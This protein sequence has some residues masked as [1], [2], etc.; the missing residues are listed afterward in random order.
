MILLLFLTALF[1]VTYILLQDYRRITQLRYMTR[2]EK[3]CKRFG[4]IRHQLVLAYARG[5]L[6]QEDEKAFRYLHVACTR[7]LHAPNFF[8]EVSTAICVAIAGDA[9]PKLVESLAP[10]DLSPATR[11]LMK[12]FV[13]SLDA[14]IEEFAHPLLAV[15]AAM[16]GRS[17]LDFVVQ[18]RDA[19]R[20]VERRRHEL[21]RLRRA[22]AEALAV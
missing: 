5:E 17:V 11:P 9:V 16:N 6:R 12:E 15:F 10:G 1:L 2:A 14:L 22:G 3:A 21:E 8:R 7:V 20:E 19:R 13:E 18:V 4:Q